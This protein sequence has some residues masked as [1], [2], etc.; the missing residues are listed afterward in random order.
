MK[1]NLSPTLMGSELPDISGFL[2]LFFFG[3]G[4]G[5]YN[6]SN[7]GSAFSLR[8]DAVFLERELCRT[9]SKI[10]MKYKS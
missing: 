4:G 8:N 3:G 1:G 6:V 5:K 7:R 2:A 10:Y 9:N